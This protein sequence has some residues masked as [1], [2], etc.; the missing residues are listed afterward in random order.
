MLVQVEDIPHWMRKIL[1]PYFY[2]LRQ[3]GP[4]TP[5]D[6]AFLSTITGYPIP[7]LLLERMYISLVCMGPT[8]VKQSVT[9]LRTKRTS[10]LCAS[11]AKGIVRFLFFC[12]V[13]NISADATTG[14]LHGPGSVLM[15][16]EQINNK[17]N[18]RFS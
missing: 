10:R 7:N 14:R 4:M 17:I 1:F 15:K 18:W 3:K 5:A 8:N 9:R 11:L 13:P 2:A 16:S 12:F 6:L